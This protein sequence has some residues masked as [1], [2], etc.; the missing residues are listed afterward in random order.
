MDRAGTIISRSFSGP[1]NPS[2][3]GVESAV[4]EIVKAAELAL[5]QGGVARDAVV[6]ICAGMAGTGNADR[7]EQVFRLLQSAF[8]GVVVNVITDLEAALAAAGDGPVI[9]LVAGTGSAAIGRDAQGQ[10]WRAGGHGP[11]TSD[12]GSA[13]DIGAR[14]IARAMKERER[15]GTDSSLGSKILGQLGYSSW[16]ELQRR[17]AEQPDAVFPL[18]F[19]IVA[20][21]ADAGDA[22]GRE[23]LLQA[24]RELSSLVR[25]VAE[26]MGYAHQSILIAK[27]GGTV[28]RS[29]FFDAQ[30]DAALKKALPL[31]RIGGLAMSPAEAAARTALT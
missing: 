30:L 2:R 24:A 22:V 31:A 12:D 13:Y 15:Q 17:A 7:R 9:V 8:P 25:T 27:T 10:I 23:I 28:G 19:P 4:L 29:E 1:S 3:V 14:A 6:A 11:R 16:P 18:A 20:A 5:I 21:A 26:H